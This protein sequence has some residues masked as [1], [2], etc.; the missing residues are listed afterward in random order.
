VTAE[1]QSD[2][3]DDGT[4]P[5]FEELDIRKAA[6]EALELVAMFRGQLTASMV[7]A[8]KAG[9]ADPSRLQLPPDHYMCMPGG[10]LDL[11]L[12]VDAFRASTEVAPLTLLALF[13]AVAHNA[14]LGDLN[15]RTL[16][17]QVLCL[18]RGE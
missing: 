5:D 8:A 11:V 18:F 2:D 4:L 7:A 9:A 13:F 15:Q 14:I 12:R 10:F 6:L 16:A 1:Y 17:S 3:E